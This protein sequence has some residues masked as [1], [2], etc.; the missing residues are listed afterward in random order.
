MYILHK[1]NI[2]FNVMYCVFI[3]RYQLMDNGIQPMTLDPLYHR[4]LE[5]LTHIAIAVVPTKQYVSMKV[6]FVA[7]TKGTVKKITILPKSM[8]TCTLEEWDIF[9]EGFNFQILT[10]H[11]SSVCNIFNSLVFIDICL[12]L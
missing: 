1:L 8:I 7:T 3:Y 10:M 4:Y 9:P 5:T 2:L 12:Y 6:L 11:Y